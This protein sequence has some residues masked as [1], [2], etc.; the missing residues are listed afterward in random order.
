MNEFLVALQAILDE[1]ASKKN[2]N[3]DI[4]NKL[5]GKIDELKI[6]AV[7]DPESI[8]KITTEFSKILNKKIV[9]DNIK[10]DNSNIE[11]EAQQ[12]G[13]KI[14]KEV[15]NGIEK[16]K[17][18]FSEL[19]IEKNLDITDKLKFNK[20]G[21]LDA[22]HA[23][24]EIKNIYSEFGDVKI[25]DQI[26]DSKGNLEKFR[27]NIQ[28]TNG[29][30]K[31]SRS[32]LME[33]DKL[34]K[35]FIFPKDIINGS[36][37]FVHHLNDAKKTTNEVLTE[38][39][40][41]ANVM[42]DIR[43]K[44]ELSRKAEEKRQ[45]LAQNNATNK[46]LE[47]EYKQRQRLANEAN[48]IIQNATTNQGNIDYGVQIENWIS[49]FE[50]LGLTEDEISQKT[51][52]LV[53][54]H[55]QLVQTINSSDFDSELNK[56]EVI[57]K[58]NEERK[59]AL[60]EVSNAY[61]LLKTDTSQYYNLNK[62]SNLSNDIQTW[63]SKNSKA[64]RDA[65]YSLQEYFEELNNGRVSVSRLN[66]IESSFKNIKSVQ[67]S[68][69]KTEKNFIDQ[70]K[71]I[72]ANIYQYLSAAML[73]QKG[74][75]S[76]K[77]MVKAVYDIDTAMT[78]L[79]KVTDETDK[80]YQIFLN[81]AGKNATKLGSNIS[82]LITQ[83]SEWA[84]LGFDL[85]QSSILAK[86]SMIYSNVG[87]VDNSTAVKDMVTAMKAFNIEASDSMR[88]ID[89]YN[90]LGNEMAVSSRDIGE[91]V[92]NAASAL[93][94]QGNTIEQVVAMLAGGGEITQNVGELGNM[95]KVA[96]LRLAGMAGKL[97]E[98][99]EAYDDIESVSKNQTKIYNMTKG[100]VNILDEQNGKLKDTYT[101]L[102]EVAS[103]WNDV[104]NL[105][106]NTL[107]ELMF[108]KNRANQGA[109]ILQAFQSGQ[110]QKAY[111]LANN[112]A[113][114][115]IKEH[116]KWL[117]SLEAKTQQF[118]A[119]FQ[120]LSVSVMNSD[121]IKGFV[122]I[123]TAGISSLTGIIN[124]IHDLN[125]LFDTNGIFSTIGAA[126]GLL[127][128]KLGIGAIQYNADDNSWTGWVN[129]LVDSIKNKKPEVQ[130][131]ITDLFTDIENLD[132]KEIDWDKVFNS[133]GIKDSNGELKEFLENLD[134][135]DD[136]FGK[137]QNYLNT[138]ASST[139][140]F[141]EITKKAGV[142]LKSFGAVLGS[143]AI[144]WAIGKTIDFAVKTV[145]D[146]VHHIE[147]AKEQAVQSANSYDLVKQEI[148]S[149]NKELSTTRDRID[150]LE[151]MP[152]LTFSE[153]EELKRLK[154][155]NVELERSI[156]QKKIAEDEAAK[157]A[158]AD[159]DS[160][161]GK[162][163]NYNIYEGAKYNEYGS[164]DI[165]NSFSSATGNQIDKFAQQVRDFKSLKSDI[166]SIHAEM[167]E[168]EKTDTDFA[169]NNDYKMKSAN[170]AYLQNVLDEL[171]GELVN[172]SED[173]IKMKVSLD[174]VE[175]QE[176]ISCIDGWI[177]KYHEFANIGSEATKSF[178]EIWNSENFKDYKKELEGLSKAGKL[179]PEVLSSNEKY[180]Q[181]IESTGKSAE[182]TASHI[183]KMMYSAK[184]QV[185]DET[186]RIFDKAGMIS[187]I[188]EMSD[189]F[190]ELQ[191]IYS[192]ISEQNF[193]FALL[194]TEEF[195]KNFSVL[196]GVYTDFIEIISNSPNDI[197]ACQ[198]AFDNLVAEWINSS[199]ILE[200]VTEETSKL[201]I[202]M[203]EN[204]GVSN[205]EQIVTN[206]LIRSQEALAAQ[207]YFTTHASD[208][209]I[210]ATLAEYTAFLNEA[211]G[212]GISKSAL[213][214]LM[215]AKISC[216]ETGVVTDGDIQN[217]M[218]L[219]TAA[220]IAENA[221]RNAKAA[222]NA[223]NTSGVAR[224]AGAENAINNSIYE[225]LENKIKE[226]T[227]YKPIKHNF[228]GGSATNS[229]SKSGGSKSGSGG[230]GSSKEKVEKET[231]E[232]FDWIE[233]QIK[234]VDKRIE[235]L[236]NRATNL[237]GWQAKN[238]VNDTIFDQLTDKIKTLQNAYDTYM[239]E[240]NKSGLAEEYI[241]KI[242]LGDSSIEELITS[243]EGNE[244]LQEQITNYQ[245]WYEKAQSVK[246]EIEETQKAQHD[247]AETRLNNII[248]D[249]EDLIG[250][251]ERQVTLDIGWEAK[252]NTQDEIIDTL[253]KQLEELTKEYE[254]NIAK[255]N[256][257]GLSDIYKKQI[258]AGTI[259]IESIEDE[260]IKN[261]VMQ[262]SQWYDAAREC[263]DA[264]DDV[265]D[266][267]REA[268]ELKLDNIINDYN[269][270]LSLLNKY[271]SY[272]KS[273]M[274]LYERQGG[275]ITQNDYQQ[276]IYEQVDIYN[277]LE[278][279]YKNLV[280][281]MND[282]DIEEGSKKWY[283][284]QEELADIQ[285]QMLDC[286]DAAEDFKDKI[287]ELQFKPLDDL[288]SKLESVN[289][290][291][292]N[293]LS[294]LGNEGL[295]KDG[296]L[297]DKGL[298][299][300]AL[301]GQQL[302]NAKQKAEEYKAAI[303][304]L[305]ETYKNGNITQEEYIEKLREYRE[306][307]Q[308]AALETKEA[309]DAIIALR[310][311]AINEEIDYMDELI[312]KQIDAI[313][314]DKEQ[315]DNEKDLLDKRKDE[316][317]KKKELLDKDKELLDEQKELLDKEKE[318]IDNAKKLLDVQKESEDY[319]K[320]IAD[321]SKK[322][323]MLEIQIAKLALSSDRAD[324]A[325]RLQLEQELANEKEQL[326]EDQRQH[327]I[328]AQKDA[329]DAQK[330]AIDAKKEEIDI[331][332]KAIDK[333]KEQIDVQKKEI[334]AQ[335]ELLDEQKKLLDK[336]IE[337]LNKEAD[338]YRRV[339]QEE[340]ETLRTS[341]EAQDEILQQYLS[342]V[343]DNY[344]I[345][346]DTIST[347]SEKFNMDVTEDLMN[348]FSSAE[349]ATKSFEDA[350]TDASA[351]IQ[352]EVDEIE[353]AFANMISSIQD[354]IDSIDWDNL[355]NGMGDIDSSGSSSGG[356]DGDWEDVSGQGKWQKGKGGKDWYG[357]DYDE[358]GDYWYA[359][360]G[361]YNIKGKDGKTHTY[362]F[363]ENGYMKTGWDDSQGDWYFFE[364]ANGQMVKSS[365]RQDKKGDWYY[366]T[367]N[368]T[369]A[370]DAAIKAKNGKGY[371]YVDDE[372]KWDGK[373]LT[374]E[375]IEELGYEIAY[376]KGTK[377]AKRGRAKV[378]E[379]GYELMTTPQ[380]DFIDL[381]GGEQIMTVNQRQLLYEFSKNPNQ[382][383]HGILNG[384]SY[385]MS[386]NNFTGYQH[387]DNALD[388]NRIVNRLGNVDAHAEITIQGDASERTIEA[389][390]KRLEYFSK[391]EMPK[392]I[393]KVMRYQ[394]K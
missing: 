290:E 104:D 274:D 251:L 17:K 179:T 126:S 162:R 378:N 182:E 89:M 213:L 252:N 283:E 9:I 270:I 82:D 319:S 184:S 86:N 125:T 254:N 365:W 63:L 123:G 235:K 384:S 339:K 152:N 155:I 392:E 243:N 198:T 186:Q 47:E 101:I 257:I 223:K 346:Y 109:A 278:E 211:E 138:T 80:K 189:G 203:L 393:D 200:N 368:G 167:D 73:F 28:K 348:P 282:S 25:T 315:I 239:A 202:S 220:N 234:L 288:V 318:R 137:Y 85:D 173:M 332:K 355:M 383:L 325:Q 303:D 210:N 54:A 168:I 129:S 93:A 66:E 61:K 286:A 233:N 149:M 293:L 322:I 147:K 37:S 266:K 171:Q 224:S 110:I 43:E 62:Q 91:G 197:N 205:A 40:K 112:A 3:E 226:E 2:I 277:K 183:N 360:N 146:M 214:D 323:A 338:E 256:A 255:A 380:G 190:E 361:Y 308:Q 64:S 297:T 185:P 128:N 385:A 273:L 248:K 34:S 349:G 157:K 139:T 26:Y 204:M 352:Y 313:E 221:V 142:V 136:I 48:I 103:A 52:K 35:S 258:E 268:Q 310:E 120:S 249:Y 153:Q 328:D 207:K 20:D 296:M 55:N 4:K 44:T 218:D 373:S 75:Q 135:T 178:D 222:Q 159:A 180:R 191:K 227:T 121:L 291:F 390:N 117:D 381:H 314:L 79:Y 95:L 39:Q 15:N 132:I 33:F 331:R 359:N 78:N 7:I 240:A 106:K 362:A 279:E 97:E 343:K 99:G 172:T 175:D 59:K 201:T 49:K 241:K 371:W 22:K 133:R 229:G 394:M 100:Q 333:Q 161:L 246:E 231:K 389:M 388:N 148:E 130:S 304:A 105:E 219:A 65:K 320:K 245:K 194:D 10:F 374:K 317:D 199:G 236:Q 294:L 176:L 208:E 160:Y 206:A 193:D 23:L 265:N 122:D 305:N 24:N 336:R 311:Q 81:N 195:K 363:D 177:D 60:N 58:S 302:I 225:N 216:N 56:N 113:G 382:F 71:Q 292:N 156:R 102:E 356:D 87:E 289:N 169:N 116:E 92:R 357:E 108:G 124:K 316:L 386:P 326:T 341:L 212:A 29:D 377:N 272:R 67:E 19:K 281:A 321:R 6:Q 144:N 12:I 334:D 42:A 98:I 76:A 143:M 196:G 295:T 267:I 324:K 366:L 271:T 27:V 150:E 260:N 46:S 237:L 38:E 69:G 188:N 350:F 83:T 145:D 306:A 347:Y 312:Q 327:E 367:A 329:Y 300:V 41:L 90:I 209:L 151:S 275:N 242:Q 376:A 345:V 165:G 111:E 280:D 342:Q 174:K 5:Q 309:R 261:M 36:E 238:K 134:D 253:R 353:N 262:Y 301:Y 45:Q 70:F 107:L 187:A 351:S 74:I 354:G 51:Q 114:S 372:G 119:A 11:K 244:V 13:Q 50:K 96:S 259:D 21:L 230:G 264:I 387:M 344:T 284:M 84:K 285:S 287:F 375:E 68:L 77:D 379:N 14:T 337:G 330:D 192:S 1:I 217:L 364:P 88:I 358:N 391:H 118:Q 170:L 141:A 370:T 115:A 163:E 307:Q 369:M 154:D 31:E 131:A 16:S 140:L 32:F 215:M 72:G 276:L 158:R 228:T 181:L 57:I 250:E 166:E 127:M 298:A 164:L 247:L 94:M 30:L 8:N 335:K 232:Y 269:N 299:A 18:S 263:E 340:I 53:N